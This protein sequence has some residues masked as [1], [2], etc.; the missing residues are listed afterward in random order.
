MEQFFPLK[1]SMSYYFSH[2][3]F[4]FAKRYL[5]FQLYQHAQIGVGSFASLTTLF[6][7][8][9]HYITKAIPQNKAIP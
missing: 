6:E 4:C 1:G 3:K 8:M 2:I 5:K 7:L 9:M